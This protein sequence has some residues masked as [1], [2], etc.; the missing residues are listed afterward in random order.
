MTN[1]DP[2][3]FFEPVDISQK[4]DNVFIVEKMEEKQVNTE[5][6]EEDLEIP[7]QPLDLPLPSINPPFA[8]LKTILNLLLP[9]QLTNFQRNV[10]S[11]EIPESISNDEFNRLCKYLNHSIASVLTIRQIPTSHSQALTTYLT[12]II[13]YPF[14]TYSEEQL[15]D[16]YNLASKVMTSFSAPALKGDTNRKMVIGD[17]V[18]NL[19]EPGM[20]GDKIGNIT[21]GASGELAKRIMNDFNSNN[22]NWLGEKENV[23]VEMGAGTGLITILL[24]ELGYRVISTDLPNIINN[25]KRNVELNGLKYGISIP[26]EYSMDDLLQVSNAM[27]DNILVT[28]LDW[29]NPVPFI[30]NTD[31]LRYSTN[32]KFKTL[33]FAD[34]VYA[35]DHPGWV[36]RAVECILATKE[37]NPKIIF[38]LGMR[39]RFEDVREDLWS[40][41]RELGLKEKIDEVIY[42]VDDYGDLSYQFKIFEFLA[43]P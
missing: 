11:N 7:L 29:T 10:I 2:L 26:K 23:I 4:V 15:D 28:P 22:L 19:H 30:K 39:D 9:E 36:K 33:V 37:D 31:S 20:T 25:L 17:I 41:M 13:S 32:G 35:P 3:S 38:M 18:I 21:W 1:F 34:P 43:E 12:R 24:A 5:I 8:I 14:P 42:G 6:Q 40:K 16:I 27:K